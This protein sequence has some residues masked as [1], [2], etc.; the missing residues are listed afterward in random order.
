MPIRVNRCHL[1]GSPDQAFQSYAEVR[2]WNYVTSGK[3]GFVFLDPQP[4]QEELRAFYESQ[5]RY[6]PTA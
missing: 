1:C 3:C 6:D 4:T 5:Y 2:G